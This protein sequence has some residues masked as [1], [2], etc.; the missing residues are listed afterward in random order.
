[1]PG[2][3]VIFGATGDL[4]R[5]MLL[6]SLYFLH[7][8]GLLPEGLRIVGA[9]R[10]TI[11]GSEFCKDVEIW[12]RE[13]AGVHFSSEAWA[14]F[15][16]RLAYVAGDATDAQTYHRLRQTLADAAAGAVFYLSTSPELYIPIVKGLAGE[17]LNGE[18]NCVIVEKPIGKSGETCQQI[19]A[20]IAEHFS[21]SRTFRVDHYL[22][23]ET[24]Q[25]LIA[26]R[27]ANALFE[28]LWNRHSIEHVQITVAETLGVEGRFG[29][30][31][32]YGATRDMVQNHLLQLLCLIA[33]EP[34][35]DLG[36]DAVRGEKV[37]VLRALRPISDQDLRER[38]VRGQ[39][40][41]G[42][43]DGRLVPGYSQ[44]ED[45]KPSETETFVAL[46]AHVDNW[47]WQG[48][49]FYL[50]TGKRLPIRHSQ[51]VVQFRP[52]PHSIFGG[53]ELTANRLTITLQPQEDIALTIMN[54]T[55]TL[56]QGGYELRPMQLDLSL[57]E[58]VRG[59]QRRRIAYERLLLEAI[60]RNMTL[61]VHRDESEA[62]WR[63]I[64][65]I[66]GGWKRTGMTPHPYQA[67]TWG[68]PSALQIPQRNGHSWYE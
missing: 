64:D 39:Y 7:A 20:A 60:N 15:A 19:S 56:S 21:E 58:T 8:D 25:N 6:P 36:G 66:V 46:C 26:L 45:G 27:F 38:T 5:R 59:E 29:Y 31:D 37:K 11:D 68:P 16:K 63:W 18:P 53:S 24:V 3:F 62:A 1:M 52:I 41:Q 67:G 54:K 13:R 23:K 51:I 12:I 30:Y 28:P 17:A 14:S 43:I 34:P 40:R 49:P 33:M 61:F 65:G 32:A 2:A 55:P 10:S 57:L 22:G 50:R 44:E 35:A 42:V 48:V 4:A 9:A 47:R